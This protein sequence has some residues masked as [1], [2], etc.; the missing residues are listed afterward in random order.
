MKIAIPV[1]KL[2]TRQVK[3]RLKISKQGFIL[4]FVKEE[5]SSNSE[6]L[7]RSRVSLNISKEGKE[8]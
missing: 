7:E 8:K 2:S 6:V 3:S 4:E 1:L 5:I